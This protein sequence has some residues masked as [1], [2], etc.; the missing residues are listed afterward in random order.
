MRRHRFKIIFGAVVFIILAAGW[1]YAWLRA[2]EFALSH[3]DVWLEAEHEAGRMHECNN[4]SI[5]GYPFYVAIKCEM[6]VLQLG[7][8]ITAQFPSMKIIAFATSPTLL[9]AE[10]GSPFTLTQNGKTVMS[11]TSRTARVSLRH[12]WSDVDRFSISGDEM[13]IDLPEQQSHMS[14]KH[15]ELHLRPS[16]PQDTGSQLQDLDLALEAEG[17]ALPN[18]APDQPMDIMLVSTIHNWPGWHGA[19]KPTLDDWRK[20]DGK[21]EVKDLRIKRNGGQLIITGETFFNDAHRAEGRFDATFVNSPG[22]LRGLIMQGENDAGAMFGPLLLLLGKQVEF[23][24]QHATS[25]QLKVNN[26]VLTLGTVVLGE[27]PPL[28]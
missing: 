21:I 18:A 10:L 20:S 1:S 7:N 19:P 8:E 6:T 12:N 24:G 22:L 28:Y 26:G 17:A 25:M 9:I 27:F 11:A 13:T 23:E 2:R 14:A 15:A 5:G 3:F 4:R 16:L